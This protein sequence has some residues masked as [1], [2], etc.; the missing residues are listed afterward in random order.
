[1]SPPVISVSSETIHHEL[2]GGDRNH[3]SGKWLYLKGN[4]NWRDPFF[5]SMIMGARVGRGFTFMLSFYFLKTGKMN[6]F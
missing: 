6:P 4:Y 2:T 3:G 1:M 5:T